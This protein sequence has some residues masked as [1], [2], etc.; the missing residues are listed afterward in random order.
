[1][2]QSVYILMPYLLMNLTPATMMMDPLEFDGER[3]LE[4]TMGID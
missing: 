2:N 3:D 1:M 4:G